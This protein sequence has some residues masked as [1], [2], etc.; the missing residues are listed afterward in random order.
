MKVDTPQ[1][2][3]HGLLYAVSFYHALL[4]SSQF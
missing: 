4:V 2:F 3:R 1:H